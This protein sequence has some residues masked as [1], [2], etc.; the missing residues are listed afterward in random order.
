M[1]WYFTPPKRREKIGE[2]GKSGVGPAQI[3]HH[4]KT[5]KE[6]FECYISPDIIQEVLRYTNLYGERHVE[7]WRPVT[8]NELKCFIA[9]LIAAGRNKQNR[10]DVNMMWTQHGAWR[11][12]FYRFAMSKKRFTQ[13]FICLRFDDPVTRPKRFSESNDKLEPIRTVFNALSRNCER[14]FIAPQNLTVDER[15]CLFRGTLTF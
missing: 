4:V 6:A 15:L 11:I 8:E 9:V 3:C 12:D 13:I 5:A 7:N 10:L 2:F 14:N 1:R